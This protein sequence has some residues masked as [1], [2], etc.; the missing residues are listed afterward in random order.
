M[1]RRTILV[2]ATSALLHGVSTRWIATDITGQRRELHWPDA[3][4]PV[5]FGSLLKP[6]LALSYLATHSSA[7]VVDCA[8][9]SAGCWYAKGHGQQDMVSALANSCNVYFLRIAE[10]L[11][12]AALDLTCISYG[13]ALPSRSWPPSRLIGLGPGWPQTP[14]AAVHAFAVLARDGAL[15]HTRLVLDGMLRCCQSGT[16]KQ[17]GL[18]CYA[19]TGTAAPS[20]R[21]DSGDGCVV[22]IY[23]IDQPSRILLFARRNATGAQAAKEVRPLIA[24]LG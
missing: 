7:P 10:T 4:Q 14:L 9:A 24:A 2:T 6:F 21:H 11:N 23:P 8:G 1:T 20:E 15:P 12:R 22:A 5:C 13:L 16:A 18:R 17:I 3:G 19:K